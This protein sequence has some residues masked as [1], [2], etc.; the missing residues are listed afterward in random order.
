MATEREFGTRLG[1]AA[2]GVGRWAAG[3]G[4][5]RPG[6]TGLEPRPRQTPARRLSRPRDERRRLMSNRSQSSFSRH[7]LGRRSL[8]AAPWRCSE[9]KAHRDSADGAKE[10]CGARVDSEIDN[11][12]SQRGRTAGPCGAAAASRPRRRGERGRRPRNYRVKRRCLGVRLRRS[13][14]RSRPF[15]LPELNTA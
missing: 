15:P 7:V 6:S 3:G 8:C 4:E 10:A 5:D 1:A 2:G 11:G 12:R 13:R 9:H 14:P